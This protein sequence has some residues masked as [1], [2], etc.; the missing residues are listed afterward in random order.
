MLKTDP[1]HFKTH[2][3]LKI[4]IGFY[5]APNRLIMKYLLF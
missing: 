1:H 2:K 3:K 4:I 5:A